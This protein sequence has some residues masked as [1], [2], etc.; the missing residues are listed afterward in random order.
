MLII[1]RFLVNG[2]NSRRTR[3]S[4]LGVLRLL[5]Q[6]SRNG[7]HILR[8]WLS[9]MLFLATGTELLQEDGSIKITNA[10]HSSGMEAGM[11]EL[12]QL[13]MLE[14]VMMNFTGE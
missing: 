6:Q 10:R 5:L 3:S 11:S 4:S 2:T 7:F 8:M 12:L 13:M 1:S 14:D 9:G